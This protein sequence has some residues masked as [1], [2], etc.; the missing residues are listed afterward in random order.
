MRLMNLF[1]FVESFLRA[2]NKENELPICKVA[3]RKKSNLIQAV[4]NGDMRIITNYMAI[5]LYATRL[6]FFSG[7]ENWLMMKIPQKLFFKKFIDQRCVDTM[8]E[9]LSLLMKETIRVGFWR[10]NDK[11]KE[12]SA[13]A[14]TANRPGLG[15]F[16]K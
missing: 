4:F 6:P 16:N 11:N 9:G 10:V 2:P 13:D 8:S 15:G 12:Q 5:L 7:E 3:E 1:L 14:N